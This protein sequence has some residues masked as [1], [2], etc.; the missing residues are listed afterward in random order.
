MSKYLQRQIRSF[1]FGICHGTRQGKEQM[2]FRRELGCDV[3]GTE[4][5]DTALDYPNTI[6]WDFHNKKAEWVEA[7]DFIYSNS[8]DH[9]YDPERCINCWVDCLKV[10]GFII[11]EH[12]ASHE[13]ATE[14]DPF[15]AKIQHMPYLLMEWLKN[16]C[17][18]FELI[19]APRRRKNEAYMKFI[20]LKKR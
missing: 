3:L 9:S 8:F 1:T 16:K 18:L 11:L 14:L 2:W 12:S 17:C 19:D 20:V 7:A 15:G 10:G 5:S 13:T 6:Q 4:I